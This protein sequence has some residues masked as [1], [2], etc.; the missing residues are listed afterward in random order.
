MPRLPELT[1]FIGAWTLERA[2]DDKLGAQ[3]G[4]MTGTVRFTDAG[5]GLRYEEEGQLEYGVA[6]P[7]VA[8]RR[9]QWR[10]HPRGIEVLYEDGGPFH[11]IEM[12]CL[13]PSAEHLCGADMYHVSYDFTKWPIWRAV[14]SV[15]GPSKD[16]RSTTTFAPIDARVITG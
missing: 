15:V 2:I 1:D 10:R 6:P 11:L 13:M 16:Y 3:D 4:K 14:W 5:P 8:T 12:N 7:M 9:Y